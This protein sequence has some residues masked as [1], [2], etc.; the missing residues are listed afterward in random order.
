VSS[1]LTWQLYAAL[2]YRLSP[3]TTFEL[4]YRHLAIDYTRGGF[5]YD[6][7]TSGVFTTF[8]FRF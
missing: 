5:T 1:D 3:R 8:G 7:T 4:G 2:G 6:T